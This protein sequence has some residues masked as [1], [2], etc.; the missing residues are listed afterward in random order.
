MSEA[1]HRRISSSRKIE[2]LKYV[3][4]AIIIASAVGVF[5]LLSSLAEKPERKDSTALIPQVSTETVTPYFGALDLIIPGAVKAHR[6]IRVAAEVVGKITKKYPE[7]QAGNFVLAGTPLAEIDAEDYKADQKTLAA[8]VQ[9]AEK[10]IVENLRQ[11]QGEKR[12]LKLARQDLEIQQRDFKRTQRLADSLSRSEVDQARRA[13]NA[14]Q[15][16]LTSR[17]N[18]VALLEASAVRLKAGLEMSRSQLEKSKLNLGRV[19]IVAP[20]DGVIVSEMVQENDFVSPGTAIAMFEDVSVAEVVCNLTTSEL[21]WIRKNSKPDPN[22]PASKDPRLTAYQLPKTEVTIFEADDLE[23][24]WKGTLE[25]FDGIGRDEVTKTIPCRIIVPNPITETEYGPRAL[26]RNMYVK[27]R[28]EVDTSSSDET[29]NLLAINEMALQPGNFVWKVVDE[30]LK[31]A[32]VEIVDRTERGKGDAKKGIVI[33][34]SL[35]GSI[36][37]D[38]EVVV[39]PLSQPTDGAIV[40]VADA[41]D[42]ENSSDTGAVAEDIDSTVRKDDADADS[43]NTVEETPKTAL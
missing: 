4:S 6:E 29:Q 36:A 25:R 12:N 19:S 3:C 34:R 11:I 31:L 32:R 38:D 16:N 35:D 15:L 9:Q 30:K 20:V 10:R 23:A 42:A 22:Q 2:I 14:A 27:C 39:T 40:K 41:A 8:D 33:V 1:S 18:A 37:V 17:E 24:T 5:F 13:L 43:A 26:V 21:N 7:F 28:V